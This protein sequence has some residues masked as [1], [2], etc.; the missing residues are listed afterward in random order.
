MSIYVDNQGVS[1]ISARLNCTRREA[2]S[3]G[4]H[5]FALSDFVPVTG[6]SDFRDSD[7]L[8][9]FRMSMIETERENR[10]DPS[11]TSSE[12]TKVVLSTMEDVMG[13]LAQSNTSRSEPHILSRS[14]TQTLPLHLVESSSPPGP[15]T[16]SRFDSAPQY[17]AL[18]SLLLRRVV[19]D[20]ATAQNLCS[21]IRGAANIS[22]L[23][24]YNVRVDE[25]KLSSSSV[26][27]IGGERERVG[28]ASVGAGF[29]GGAGDSGL[30]YRLLSPTL[31]HTRS[32]NSV[33]IIHVGSPS[34]ALKELI[35]QIANEN[36]YTQKWVLQFAHV[37]KAG[38]E[39][40][41]PSSSL[42]GSMK[43]YES[44][45]GAVGSSNASIRM[46]EEHGHHTS[47]MIAR[48]LQTM[49]VSP[50]WSPLFCAN[51]VSLFLDDNDIPSLSDR[52]G[53]L[54][55]LRTLSMSNNSLSELSLSI[56]KLENLTDLN[57]SENK[58]EKVS[59]SL[60]LLTSLEKLNLSYN[61]IQTLP[62]SV[63]LLT[64][65]QSLK[66]PFIYSTLQ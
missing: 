55:N 9:R 29:V 64:K 32:L 6:A 65:L 31:T 50:L 37:S 45:L 43:K 63:A 16:I 11:R 46:V 40:L 4:R 18:K 23:E 13:Y 20:M 62:P 35:H 22:H 30:F 2:I 54:A 36:F 49:S 52:I 26:L 60:L 57:L 39:K 51:I 28:A 41:L 7:A 17:S 53:D 47:R 59:P 38:D 10:N 5:W 33:T 21:R 25:E 8:Y 34:S 66:V 58:L 56:G 27:S 1:W 3:I 19:L 24:I 61:R 48:R 14:T 44:L 42:Q 15:T 12:L